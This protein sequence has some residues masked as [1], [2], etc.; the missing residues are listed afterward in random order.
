M[1]GRSIIRLV[2][3]ILVK[4]MFNRPKAKLQKKTILGLLNKFNIKKMFPALNLT[5]TIT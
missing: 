2:E 5:Y 4:K 1:L 3:Q